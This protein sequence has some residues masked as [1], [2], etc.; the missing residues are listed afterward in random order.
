MPSDYRI[1]PTILYLLYISTPLVAYKALVIEPVVNLIGQPICAFYSTIPVTKAYNE[2][3]LCASELNRWTSCPRLH[4]LLYNEVVDII[5]L[6]THEVKVRIPNL[7]YVTTTTREPQTQYW[8]PSHAFMALSDLQEQKID[9]RIIPES[10][11]F[12]KGTVPSINTVA[13]MLP[14]H[15]KKT[16]FTFSAGTR[17]VPVH[18]KKST[19]DSH[20]SVALY[21]PHAKKSRVIHI[22][23][24]LCFVPTAT[25]THKAQRALFVSILRQWAHMNTGFVPYVWGGCSI[26]HTQKGPFKEKIKMKFGQK[27]S[28]FS[29]G[30]SAGKPHTGIDCS[31]LISRAAQ[32]V[33]IPY[34]YKNSYT[35]AQCMQSLTQGNHLEVGDLIWVPGHVMVVSDRDRNLL[36]EARSYFAGFGKVHEIELGK[37]FAGMHTYNDLEQA[38]FTKKTIE[39]MNSAGVVQH[40][41]ADFKLLP[42]ESLF[43][44]PI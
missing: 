37:V 33:G 34:F 1:S 41:F 30:N 14:Y 32:I 39:R 22:A 24:T 6:H 43:L 5:E 42:L 3:P 7:F 10:I 19:V 23:R 2:I 31:G 18:H 36:I 8:G 13:L 25:L 35:I 27:R 29:Y 11:D 15:D 44:L 16:G 4:Q 28:Y 38:F 12:K 40:T 20:V 21:D 17:F 26:V 9:M